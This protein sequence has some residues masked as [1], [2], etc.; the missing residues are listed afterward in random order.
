[1]Q[2]IFHGCFPL[3]LV[4][5]D[6]EV[7]TDIEGD[8]DWLQPESG[9]NL[10]SQG[11]ILSYRFLIAIVASVILSLKCFTVIEKVPD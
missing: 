3:L 10:I 2:D 8:T 9:K 5:D 7:V 4:N 11:M 1:M 6:E